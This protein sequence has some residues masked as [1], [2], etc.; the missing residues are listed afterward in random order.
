MKLKRIFAAMLFSAVLL[1]S[2][3]GDAAPNAPSGN[4]PETEAEII[5]EAETEARIPL[6]DYD[7]GGEDIWILGE[8]AEWSNFY[9][10]ELT[11]DVVDDAVYMLISDN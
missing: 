4:I 5:T 8:A 6:P 7:F 2:G 3:C 10:S 11:G 1:V 9:D